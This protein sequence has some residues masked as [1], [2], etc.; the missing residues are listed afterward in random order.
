V[1]LLLLFLLL[2]RFDFD[3]ERL[4][5]RL[6]SDNVNFLRGNMDFERSKIPAS[7]CLQ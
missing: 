5:K 7:E 3:Y 1:L 6:D 2:L 4:F